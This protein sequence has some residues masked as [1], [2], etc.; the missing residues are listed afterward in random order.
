MQWLHLN[1][2][3]Y[4]LSPTL[5]QPINH[6]QVRVLDMPIV[7]SYFLPQETSVAPYHLRDEISA[8]HPEFQC[9]QSDILSWLCFFIFFNT[10]PLPHEGDRKKGLRVCLKHFMLSL[11]H[12]ILLHLFSF[13][14]LTSLFLKMQGQRWPHG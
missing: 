6:S 1:F 8:T 14:R 7:S 2:S 9:L 3:T 11:Y 13:Q 10:C 5:I 12:Q 4:C